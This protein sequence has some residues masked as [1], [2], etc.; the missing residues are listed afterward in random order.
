M[1]SCAVRA[2]RGPTTHNRAH[3]ACVLTVPLH[4]HIGRRFL[5]PSGHGAFLA[6][7]RGSCGATRTPSLPMN[8]LIMPCISVLQNDECGVGLQWAGCI[9]GQRKQMSL[10]PGVG[11]AWGLRSPPADQ[12]SLPLSQRICIDPLMMGF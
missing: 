6:A 8:K 2:Y 5:L 12:S 3:N 10:G 4:F 1:S 7:W 11:P 9:E